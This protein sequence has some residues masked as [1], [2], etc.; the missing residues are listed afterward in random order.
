MIIV[1]FYS[2]TV[3]LPST[4]FK[5]YLGVRKTFKRAKFKRKPHQ[6]P[7]LEKPTHF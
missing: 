7:S 6:N 2:H 5:Q 4:N 1:C 3:Q